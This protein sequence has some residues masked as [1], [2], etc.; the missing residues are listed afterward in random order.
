MDF[1][2]KSKLEFKFELNHGIRIDL[3]LFRNNYTKFDVLFH[4]QVHKGLRAETFSEEKYLTIS[5]DAL[6][7][8]YKP[9]NQPRIFYQTKL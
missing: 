9:S 3:L 5:C 6:H 7:F 8:N 4:F 2:L 1:K